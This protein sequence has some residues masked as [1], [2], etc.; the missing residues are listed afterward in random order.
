MVL[1]SPD[2][3][4]N[5]SLIWV[6]LHGLVLLE[7]VEMA[8]SKIGFFHLNRNFLPIIYLYKFKIRGFTKR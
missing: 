7:V 2:L 3:K 5:I 1:V 4:I 6:I 8:S